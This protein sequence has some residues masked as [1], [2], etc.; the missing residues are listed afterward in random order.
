MIHSIIVDVSNYGNSRKDSEN[1]FANLEDLQYAG[2]LEILVKKF[3][4][5]CE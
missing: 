3:S 2:R 4:L 5:A 1:Y